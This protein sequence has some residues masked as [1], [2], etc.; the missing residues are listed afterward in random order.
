[1]R[2]LFLKADGIENK[3]NLTVWIKHFIADV[4]VSK[5]YIS[6]QSHACHCN[7]CLKN[8]NVAIL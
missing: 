5:L 1:M 2:C 8:Y 4:A 7:M 6:R 3:S